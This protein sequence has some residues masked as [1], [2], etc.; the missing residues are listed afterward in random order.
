MCRLIKHQKWTG[1][2]AESYVQVL[3]M[4]GVFFLSVSAL[5]LPTYQYTSTLIIT[6]VKWSTEGRI[7][8]CKNHHQMPALHPVSPTQGA[9]T[10]IQFMQTA[11]VFEAT[12]TAVC[13]LLLPVKCLFLIAFLLAEKGQALWCSSHNKTT[14]TVGHSTTSWRKAALPAT[15]IG[16]PFCSSGKFF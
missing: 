16:H 3:P 5:R 12:G 2:P 14:T 10:C 4:A 9:S 8:V 6:T 13:H 15:L 1:E 7:G 11:S